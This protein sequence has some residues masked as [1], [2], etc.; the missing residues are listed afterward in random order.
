MGK[1][2]NRKVSSACL[3]KVKQWEGL[4]LE[5]YKDS[6]GVLTI[7][8]GH[9][10]NCG[11][12]RVTPDMKIT[13]AQAEAFL[14]HDLTQFERCVEESVKVPLTDSQ[15]GALVSFCYNVGT[16]NFKRSTLLK[17]LNKG[18]YHCVPEELQ[19]WNRVRGRTSVGLSNRRMAECGLWATDLVAAPNYTEV[20]SRDTSKVLSVD[21]LVSLLGSLSGLG[22]F[23]SDSKILQY[24]FAGIMVCAAILAMLIICKRYWHSKL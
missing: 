15:F 14:I 9:T 3:Q 2:V 8:Y 10:N 11:G 20:E 22:G 23:L 12:V 19:R 16:A 7:G 13:E 5:T 4:R 18:L 24:A 21:V 17:K 6:G 1:H